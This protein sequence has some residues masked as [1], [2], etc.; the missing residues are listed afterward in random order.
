MVFGSKVQAD[1]ITVATPQKASEL[2]M[3]VH[4]Q[5]DCLNLIFR[6]HVYWIGAWWNPHQYFEEEVH[7][8]SSVAC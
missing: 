7:K 3:E 5:K 1:A 6:L 8:G 4:Q 2:T